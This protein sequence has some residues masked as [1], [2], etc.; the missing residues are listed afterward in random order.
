MKRG[1]RNSGHMMESGLKPGDL[2]QLRKS[3]FGGGDIGIVIGPVDEADYNKHDWGKGLLNV[4]LH[5]GIFRI[6]P[7]NLQKPDGRLKPRG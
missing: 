4:M 2:V 6:H 7:T 3:V 5:D 1:D